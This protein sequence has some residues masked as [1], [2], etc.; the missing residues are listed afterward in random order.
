MPASPSTHIEY[1][2]EGDMRQELVHVLFFNVDQPIFFLIVGSSP[3]G[4]AFLDTDFLKYSFAHDTPIVLQTNLLAPATIFRLPT[5]LA[6]EYPLT[7]VPR[8]SH[9]QT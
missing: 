2:A 6:F 5:P 4:I 3:E 7:I 8:T 9:P 1:F